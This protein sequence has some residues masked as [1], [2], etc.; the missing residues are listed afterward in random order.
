M[1][2]IIDKQKGFNRLCSSPSS[3]II[4]P[5]C[6][7]DSDNHTTTHRSGI[8]WLLTT[9]MMTL[10]CQLD[11]HRRQHLL[12]SNTR[13][14]ACLQME[15]DVNNDKDFGTLAAGSENE[16]DTS[17]GD[18]EHLLLTTVEDAINQSTPVIADI[19]VRQPLSFFS[20]PKP[21]NLLLHHHH[22]TW[23]TVL[24]I[25]KHNTT[26]LCTKSKGPS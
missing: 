23:Q 19:C 20:H 12:P 14:Q 11:N 15:S 16:I 13:T 2:G 5:Y 9:L 18:R 8:G 25:W 21:I 1:Q 26:A 6:S 7:Q 24:Q 4:S 3:T 22:L 10:C 17:N